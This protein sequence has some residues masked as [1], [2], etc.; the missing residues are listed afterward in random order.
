MSRA[1]HTTKNA[2]NGLGIAK[3][4]ASKSVI[5]V[6]SSEEMIETASKRSGGPAVRFLKKNLDEEDLIPDIREASVDAVVSFETIEHTPDPAFFLSELHRVL[7]SG[8]TIVIST[9]N[10]RFHSIGKNHPWNPFH[11]VEFFPEEFRR[12]VE[13]QFVKFDFW[14][15]QEFMQATA[16]NIL[17]YN[18]IEIKYYEL[19]HHRFNSRLVLPLIG[20]KR[21]LR[22]AMTGKPANPAASTGGIDRD[23]FERRCAVVEWQ[24]GLEPYT[25]IARCTKD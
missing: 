6:D 12:V 5:G 24:P 9:P 10:K 14:G 8:G 11:V 16:R 13:R 18:W 19:T 1:T 25:M 7:R 3:R 21:A 23:L 22:M 4:N 2:K 15:G 20:V 17:K